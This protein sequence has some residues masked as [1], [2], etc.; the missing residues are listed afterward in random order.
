MQ[1]VHLIEEELS[2]AGSSERVGKREK[3]TVLREGI[4]HHQ[5]TVAML[6]TR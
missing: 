6:R 2:N 5:Y 1:L 4:D 3:M